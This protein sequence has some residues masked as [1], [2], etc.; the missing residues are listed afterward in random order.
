MKKNSF[1]NFTILVVVFLVH[2]SSCRITRPIRTTKRPKPDPGD[3]DPSTIKFKL[4]EHQTY[5]LEKHL[6]GTVA[7]ADPGNVLSRNANVA[8]VKVIAGVIPGLNEVAGAIADTLSELDRIKNAQETKKQEAKAI[9]DT[10]LSYLAKKEL[11]GFLHG[12]SSVMYGFRLWTNAERYAQADIKI[13]EIINALADPASGFRQFPALA[14]KILLPLATY[15][16]S[17]MKEVCSG[18]EEGMQYICKNSE[19]PCALAKTIEIFYQPTLLE[20]LNQ[21]DVATD[22]AHIAEFGKSR[23]ILGELKYSENISV[24]S[25]SDPSD[26]WIGT[27][28]QGDKA[29]YDS[30]VRRELPAIKS[31]TSTKPIYP[32]LFSE[33][34]YEAVHDTKNMFLLRDNLGEQNEFFKFRHGLFIGAYFG[35]VGNALKKEFSGAHHKVFGFCDKRKYFDEHKAGEDHN[36]KERID[37]I[38]T[39]DSISNRHFNFIHA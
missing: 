36:E 18:S 6:V 30:E 28:H 11:I 17:R 3:F 20:R 23:A 14:T 25:D 13:K 33:T 22:E 35:L 5:S 8:V 1:F 10:I 21:I 31:S 4:Y 12:F 37:F 15:V 16:E 24:L 26:D 34:K 9:V 19:I 2:H 27:R 29:T 7:G 32:N 39:I 38:K